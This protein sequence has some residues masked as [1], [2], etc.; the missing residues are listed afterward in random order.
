MI[1]TDITIQKQSEIALR[2]RGDWFSALCD[3]SPVGIF[4]SDTEGRCLYANERFRLICGFPSGESAGEGWGR[5]VHLEE[6]AE[7]FMAWTI[8]TREGGEYSKELRFEPSPG[9]IRWVHIRTAPMFSKEGRLIGHSGTAEDITA[10]KETEHSLRE[11]ESRYRTLIEQ[12][13]DGIHTYDFEG[14]FIDANTKLC[15]MLGYTREELLSLNVRD[16]I[17]VEDLEAAPLRL[18]ILRAGETV[19]SERVVRRKDGSTLL[20]EISGKMLP[21]GSLQALIRDITKR[22]RAEEAIR[23]QS[24][25]LDTVEQAVIATDLSG[26][27]I[28]WNRFAEKLYGWPA[29]EITGRNILGA[30]L[31]QAAQA[32]AVEIM[33]HLQAGQSWSGEFTVHRRDGTT[34]RAFI[35]D[36]PIYNEGGEL[37]GIVGI[38]DDITERKRAEEALRESE[39]RYRA[40]VDQAMV[41]VAQADL[42]GNFTIVNQKYCD[43]TGYSAAELLGMRIQDITHPDDL[44]LNVEVRK[45]MIAESAPYEIEKRYVVKNGSIIWVNL[46]VS[47]I[48]DREG[49]PQ[50]SI[51]VV[52]DITERKRA[53]EALRES[54]ERLRTMFAASRDGILVE[55]RE[56]IVYVNKSYTHLFG[57]DAPEE[58]IGQHVSTVISTEDVGRMLKFGSQRGSGEP[59][60]S[61]Y[62]FKGKRKDGTLIDVEA[63]VSTSTIAGRAYITTMIRDIT[64]RKQA[65][66]VMRQEHDQLERRVA[67][68]TTELAQINEALQAEIYER[69]RTE[70]RLRDNEQRLKIAVQTGKL[71]SWE[72]DLA[73]GTL[74]CSDICKAHFGLPPEAEFSYDTL[75][76]A[77]HPDDHARVGGAV[78]QALEKQTDYEAEYRNLWPDGSAHW[79]ITRGRGIYGTDGE[80]ARM[81]GVTLDIT[82]RKQ[83]E[84]SHRLLLR[85]LVT[86]QED[87]R[88]RISRE[89]HDQMGQ[90]LVGIALLVNSL[91][92]IAQS[93]PAAVYRFA[94]LEDAAHQLS[95]QVDT[96]AWQLRPMELD[97]LGLHAAI[98][99]YAGKWS[100]RYQVPVDFHS[101]SLADQRLTSEIETAIY[102]IA[103]EALNN[104]IKHARA[105]NV[106]LILE[107][108]GHDVIVIIEDD[109][110]G[111]DVEGLLATPDAPRR[112]GLLGMKER[113][114]LVGGTLNIESAPG[115][116]TTI[117][118]RIP[119]A[120]DENGRQSF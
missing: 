12:A 114:A 16:L 71:G 20:V 32:Q 66:E 42:D 51:A 63:S 102:R 61:S 14:N 21:D 26:V 94:Q 37:V 105:T 77:V 45:R 111:F 101:V 8:E 48:R 58:L 72:L 6:R 11:S 34:F 23:F 85:Q 41:G 91:K 33:A 13:S 90:H 78:E 44:P 70:E 92:D 79:I 31:P 7:V 103:Q 95:L 2:E 1:N 9:V 4:L 115:A 60:V 73:T 106:S 18:D 40:I 109:G 99:N 107:R 110:R 65:E 120:L 74:T 119:L 96:L 15:E 75:F 84:E 82:E 24:H 87:E 118:V 29:A 93:E 67:E 116:G 57:Y 36:T 117:F 55:D 62:E 56:R 100:K 30:I 83:A 69:T 52:L 17:P 25:L 76:A 47:A 112:M 28:Y 22:K 98:R 43:I 10:R 50:S 46:G 53:A 39:E 49:R 104:I 3:R 86:A 88:R 19:M 54:E 59:V 97:D 5:F 35:S 108:R 113:T 81:I 80:P 68:R 89:L 64:G 38:S 27:I